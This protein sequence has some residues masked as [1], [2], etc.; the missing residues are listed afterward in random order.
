MI[1]SVDTNMPWVEINVKADLDIGFDSQPPDIV[2]SAIAAT[3][4]NIVEWEVCFGWYIKIPKHFGRVWVK[5]TDV[6]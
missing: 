4:G 1:Q 5:E 2:V 3:P 6:L